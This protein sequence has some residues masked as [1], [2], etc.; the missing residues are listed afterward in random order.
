M[1]NRSKAF[2]F[3]SLTWLVFLGLELLRLAS[4]PD[5]TGY[6]GISGWSVAMSSWTAVFGIGFSLVVL[7]VSL[8]IY[9]LTCIPH[10]GVAVLGVVLCFVLSGLL[11]LVVFGLAILGGIDG[12][13]LLA[14][15]ITMYCYAFAGLDGW[16]TL[17]RASASR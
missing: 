8:A 6:D 12:L 2:L 1:S 5:P 3:A 10:R 13:H 11:H 16:M 7:P 17:A 9:A 14:L 4:A 15:G